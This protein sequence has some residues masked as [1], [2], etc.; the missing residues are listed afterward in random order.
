MC[1]VTFSKYAIH[2]LLWL[3]YHMK[4]LLESHCFAQKTFQHFFNDI[5]SNGEKKTWDYH[6]EAK[7][8]LILT[9][10]HSAPLLSYP[11]I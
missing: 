6:K 2:P 9:H 3:Q 11:H 8:W 5:V 7:F 10:L 1:K 4:T